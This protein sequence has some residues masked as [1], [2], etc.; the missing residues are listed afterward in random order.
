LLAKVQES[1][2]G[3][4]QVQK[5]TIEPCDQEPRFAIITRGGVVI[6]EYRVTPGKTADGSGIRRDSD[7]VPL[8]DLR[9]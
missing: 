8:F 3:N 1:Q 9:K 4:Q 7:K 2:G 5:I 6:R